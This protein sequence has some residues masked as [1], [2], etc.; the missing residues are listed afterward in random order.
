MPVSNAACGSFEA[1]CS[2]SLSQGPCPGQP[3]RLAPWTHQGKTRGSAVV[4][5]GQLGP[6][7][8][9]AHRGTRHAGAASSW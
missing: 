4:L 9:P 7:G 5:C 8:P 1:L 6:R 2:V 3:R